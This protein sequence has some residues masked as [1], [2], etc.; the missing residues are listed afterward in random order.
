MD[1]DIPLLLKGKKRGWP[2]HGH[3][4]ATFSLPIPGMF[5]LLAFQK[6]T[7]HWGATYMV[8]DAMEQFIM[9]S[10]HSIGSYH[11]ED[12][13]P[14]CP[15]FIIRVDIFCFGYE[16]GIKTGQHGCSVECRMQRLFSSFYALKNYSK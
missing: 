6:F 10:F 5:D 3:K 7:R 13:D 1:M 15:S 11:W 4:N 9:F 12:G 16:N 8:G 14:F 2:S